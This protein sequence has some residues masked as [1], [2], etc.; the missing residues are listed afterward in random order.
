MRSLRCCVGLSARGHLSRSI[1]LQ[2]AKS[3]EFEQYTLCVYSPDGR[4]LTKFSPYGD[5]PLHTNESTSAGIPNRSTD[6]WCGL[7]IRVAQWHPS[8]KFLA[9]G[10][11]DTK[12]CHSLMLIKIALRAFATSQI[13]ILS[14]L[15]WTPLCVVSLPVKVHN[16][17]T[18]RLRLVGLKM[19]ADSD[20]RRP[21]FA[22]QWIGLP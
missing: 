15:A 20:K 2:P 3:D 7:G 1:R 21:F 12:V 11:W 5:L 6:G 4:L 16:R 22:N 10:G 13:R 8:G 14:D 19:R 17:E 18:V 9:I